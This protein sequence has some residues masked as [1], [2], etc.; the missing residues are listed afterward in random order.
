LEGLTLKAIRVV[1]YKPGRRCLLEYD[2][3]LQKNGAKR[4]L[5]LMGKVRRKGSQGNHEIL[6]ALYASGFD[7]SSKDGISVPAPLGY[8]PDL[9]MSLQEKVAGIQATKLL[10]RP[11]QDHL[12][13]RIAEALYK[14]NRCG[15]ASLRHHTLVE[16]MAILHNRLQNI[17]RK[18]PELSK[19]I[20]RLLDACEEL[21][22]TIRERRVCGI[23][24]DFYPDQV[25]VDSSRIYL[26]DLD[27]YSEGEPALD[28]GNFIG[29]M[30]EQGIRQPEHQFELQ[31]HERSFA[32]RFLELDRESNSSYL[33]FFKTFTL[34]R[35]IYL[36]TQY[37][38]RRPFT[39]KLLELCENRIIEVAEYRGAK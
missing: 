11:G 20:G 8:I 30:T 25:V 35:H 23:H 2:I 21:A 37:P 18:K 22:G 33:E 39:E 5:T 1:K 12:A 31:N 19:R 28:A 38:E 15:V 4:E 10:E 17:T 3:A 16:E 24:R 14:L 6:E 32:K 7:G 34:V 26:V 29:H 9:R 36:S 13:K 27:L